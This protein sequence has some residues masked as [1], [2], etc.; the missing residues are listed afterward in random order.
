MIDKP[1]KNRAEEHNPR[2]LDTGENFM[3]GHCGCQVSSAALA[4]LRGLLPG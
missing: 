1:S 2:N 3:S 4:A